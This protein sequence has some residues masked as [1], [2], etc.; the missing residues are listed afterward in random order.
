MQPY[1]THEIVVLES[2]PGPR[3]AWFAHRRRQYEISRLRVTHGSLHGR[4]VRAE[5]V[6]RPFVE[7]DLAYGRTFIVQCVEIE[8][9]GVLSRSAA[10]PHIRRIVHF[11][12]HT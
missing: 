12:E 8:H 11:V 5:A 4:E 10:E 1:V 9:V 6:A 3:D 7:T 2:R